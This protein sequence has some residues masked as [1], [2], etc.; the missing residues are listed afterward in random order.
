MG[1]APPGLAVRLV[2]CKYSLLFSFA[3]TRCSSNMK[4]GLGQGPLLRPL[5]LTPGGSLLR[6][7]CT[8]QSSERVG[9]PGPPPRLHSTSRKGTLHQRVLLSTRC[10]EARAGWRVSE[11]PTARSSLTT[12]GGRGRAAA[13]GPATRS[14]PEQKL[15]PVS[16]LEMAT[17]PDGALVPGTGQ[18]PSPGK[19]VKA[20]PS[21][22]ATRAQ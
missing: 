8:P 11:R 16:L 3:R 15:L 9:R 10:Y 5:S 7:W 22:Q 19:Q 4:P 17:P 2:F 14:R 6:P 12:E 20:F 18:G 21:P 1:T 13:Q